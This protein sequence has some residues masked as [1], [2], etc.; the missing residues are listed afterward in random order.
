MLWQPFAFPGLEV[1]SSDDWAKILLRVA[2]LY[3]PYYVV[4]VC[5]RRNQYCIV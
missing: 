4:W 2:A 5:D 1:R 3:I